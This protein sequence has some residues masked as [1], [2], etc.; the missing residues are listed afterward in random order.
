MDPELEVGG[1]PAAT[2]TASSA[3]ETSGDRVRPKLDFSGLTPAQLNEVPDIHGGAGDETATT[4]TTTTPAAG[5][6]A[7]TTPAPADPNIAANAARH[8][9]AAT[10]TQTQAVAPS[11]R[12]AAR[13][14][15]LDLSQ[16]ASD[17]DAVAHLIQA[18]QRQQADD[19]Y[20][21]LGR[22]LAPHYREIQPIIA[23]KAAAPTQAQTRPAYM[24][25]EFDKGWLNRVEQDQKTGAWK[26]LP[27][28]D[29]AYADKVQVY[30]DWMARFNENPMA[31]I[32]PAI[33]DEA[34][35]IAAEV[36]TR[37]N[38]Q[39]VAQTTIQSIVQ[40]NAPW[41]YQANEHGQ[42]YV[43]TN[44]QYIATPMGARY[45]QHIQTLGAAGVAD[46]K[47]L[48]TL[49]K[50]LLRGE[51]NTATGQA[52][53]GATAAA[54]TTQTRAAIANPAVNA[55]QVVAPGVNPT[56][57][58]ATAAEETGLSLFERMRRDMAANGVVDADVA[59]SVG[60]GWGT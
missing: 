36:F 33:Q 46:P 19:Y 3:A 27:G 16:F 45:L 54:T 42:N 6:A 41:L 55:G 5:T 18:N 12:D 9:A 13:A 17:Q 29:P 34:R 1:T 39:A 2:E 47:A 32:Q 51:F 35:K 21:Q 56:R 4:T 31:V 10:Q 26:A 43:N 49:A 20:T 58:A 59:G 22:S 44:G 52:L 25:P 28:Q 30:A 60:G 53:V 15:G 11:L 24:P 38:Q 40:T 48:D 8:A 37:Q 7:A 57:P 14:A 23:A 50:N